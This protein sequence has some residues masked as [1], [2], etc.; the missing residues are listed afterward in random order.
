MSALRQTQSETY[1]FGTSTPMSAKSGQWQ[2][3]ITPRKAS[4]GVPMIIALDGGY[5]D[6]AKGSYHLVY[7]NTQRPSISMVQAAAYVS[8]NSP[9]ALFNAL[10]S[11]WHDERGV[12]SS[13]MQ[14]AM[15]PAYQRIIAMGPPAI[16]LILR[17]LASEGDEPDM[18]FWALRV[19]TNVDPVPPQHRGNI[20]AMARAWLDWGRGRYVY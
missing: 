5:L 14:M 3:A 4:E 7:A 10:V 17:Q 2:T 18:W 16:P 1:V 13:A 19:L 6:A 11:Q 9:D 20:N 12:T 15:C 8:F